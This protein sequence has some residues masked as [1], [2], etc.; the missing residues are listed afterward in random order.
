MRKFGLLTRFVDQSTRMNSR[1]YQGRSV[2]FS[3]MTLNSSPVTVL[4]S[5]RMS[6]WLSI[7]YIATGAPAVSEVPLMPSGSEPAI[8]S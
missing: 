6:K 2:E 3:T 7:A 1:S 4:Y 8:A 5:R